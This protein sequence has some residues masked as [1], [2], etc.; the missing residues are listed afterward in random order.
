MM[1][2]WLSIGLVAFLLVVC[3]SAR[4]ATAT[5]FG[6]LFSSGTVVAAGDSGWLQFVN[7][8]RGFQG[9][10][11]ASFTLVPANLTTNETLDV[12][13]EFAY[14]VAGTGNYIGVSF[15]QVTSTNATESLAEAG[16][17]PLFYRITWAVA[18]TSPSMDFVVY[19]TAVAL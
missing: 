11:R 15:A 6:Q 4:G 13:V 1:R 8:P 12:D 2:K 16:P 7:G 14:A 19:Y 10:D 17:M 5:R 18:G 9:Y 3:A